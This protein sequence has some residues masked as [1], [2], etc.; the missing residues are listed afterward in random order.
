[1]K[2]SETDAEH[3]TSTV[4]EPKDAAEAG[5]GSPTGDEA[6]DEMAALNAKAKENWD[7][8]LRVT[9]EFDNFRKRAAR[10]KEEA[11]RYANLKVFERLLPALDSFDMALNAA[12]AEEGQS[13]EAFHDGI[14]LVFQQLRS[15]LK[16]TG[17][18]EIDAQGKPF[19]PNLH[20]AVSQIETDEVKED[21]VV[22][23]VRKGYR[24]RDRLVR[25]SS[26]IVAKN[27]AG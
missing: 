9:A 2:K 25:P 14:R 4:A 22:Q 27:P 16:E 26:V 18:E 3:D 11:V 12:E 6:T 8:L 23:Q 17:L 19:D 24:L 13:S 20:E 1:M 21:H 7:R 5:D 15:I 10:E